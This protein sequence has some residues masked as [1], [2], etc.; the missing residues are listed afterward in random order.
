MRSG[1]A[2]T[3][4]RGGGGG[5]RGGSLAAGRLRFGGGLRPTAPPERRPGRRQS[6]GI[7]LLFSGVGRRLYA[8][9]RIHAAQPTP[10]VV[11]GHR[12]QAGRSRRLPGGLHFSAVA[13][14]PAQ[15]ILSD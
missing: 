12:E 3:G 11:G 10:A 15:G 7:S 13:S 4:A 2:R 1:R 14:A 9:R 5:P 6:L 8:P